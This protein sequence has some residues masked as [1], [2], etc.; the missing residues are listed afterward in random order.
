MT[1]TP[2]NWVIVDLNGVRKILCSWAGGYL[3]ADEWRLSSG[4]V[5]VVDFNDRYDI[6]NTSGSL[7][8]CYKDRQKCSSYMLEK[9][10]SWRNSHG[11]QLNLSIITLPDQEIT[12]IDHKDIKNG[13]HS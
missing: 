11:D 9:I 12:I 3:G 7:Y 4:I 13:I 1:E 5:R 6:V 2:D 8:V 10:N